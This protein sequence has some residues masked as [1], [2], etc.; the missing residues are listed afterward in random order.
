MQERAAF[1]L[2]EV[3]VDPAKGEFSGPGGRV[4]V[5]P[6][7]MEMLL[8][9]ARRQGELVTREALIGALWDAH[10]G[11][12]QSLSNTASKLRAA[13]DAAGGDRAQLHTVPKR[14]FLLAGPVVAVTGN[15]RRRFAVANGIAAVLLAVAAAVALQFWAAERNETSLAVLAFDDLSPDGDYE[16]LAHGLAEDILGLLGSVPGLRVVGRTSSFAFDG[17]GATIPEIG[18]R[19][20]VSHILEGSI[21]ASDDKVRITVQLLEARRDEHLWTRTYERDLT[22]LFDMEDEAAADI[23]A[24]LKLELLPRLRQRPATDPETYALY[25]KARYLLDQGNSVKGKRGRGLLETVLERDPDYVPA[26]TTAAGLAF[27]GGNYDRSEEALQKVLGLDPDNAVAYALLAW[28]RFMVEKDPSGAAR[29][30]E[31][32]LEGTPADTDVLLSASRFA[33]SIGRFEEALALAQHAVERDP[34]CGRC[35]YALSQAYLAFGRLGDAESWLRRYQDVAEGGDLTLG[36]ILLLRGD[37]DAA[38]SAYA[39]QEPPEGNEPA[40]LSGRAMA[41]WSLGRHEE[42][43]AVLARLSGDWGGEEPRL[44][45]RVHAWVGDRDAALEWLARDID[46]YFDLVVPDPFFRELH[47]DPRWS[48]L[49]RAYGLSPGQ[50]EGVEFNPPLA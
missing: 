11:A 25:L 16:Y 23:A 39:K 22:N 45:A 49:L 41:L 3:T 24:Q 42:F 5:E 36:N 40:W 43:E 38:L 12:D 2:G 47:D 37:A 13:L 31:K 28:R 50:L 44:V 7:V 4:H 32:A 48:E 17:T 34:L 30:M 35:L 19:L 1:K 6:L 14:G 9:L 10:P 29:L 26:L 18:R 20:G 33:R 21:R 27:G 15:R 46:A 8:Y